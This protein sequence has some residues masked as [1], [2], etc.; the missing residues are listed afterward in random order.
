M[1]RSSGAALDV[2]L[3][4][5]VKWSKEISGTFKYV[6]HR[7]LAPETLKELVDIILPHWHRV[8]SLEIVID[9]SFSTIITPLLEAKAERLHKDRNK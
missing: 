2:F 8:R 4:S 5:I 7:T 9:K 6:S 1:K 3:A